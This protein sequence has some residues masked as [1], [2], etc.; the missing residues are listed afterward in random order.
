MSTDDMVPPYSSDRDDNDNMKTDGQ[1]DTT[2]VFVWGT[3]ISVQ[4]VNGTILRFLHHFRDTRSAS[5]STDAV[6]LM[7]EVITL[8]KTH[9]IEARAMHN[10][11]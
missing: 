4:E 10:V 3:N 7:S 8:N 9:H 5:E 1:D 11:F 6:D 2:P